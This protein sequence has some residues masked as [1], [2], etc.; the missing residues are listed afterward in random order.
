MNTIKQLLIDLTQVPG[1]SGEEN[2]AAELALSH[3]KKYDPQA[4]IKSGSVFAT[5]GTPE[6]GK[7]H[8]LLDAHIDQIGMIVSYITEEGFLKVGFCGGIDRRILLAQ[9]VTVYGKGGKNILRGAICS[10]PPH[11]AKGGQKVPETEE[12][13]IDVGMSSKEEVLKVL[14]PGD[15]IT[16]FTS[17][18]ALL[19]HRLTAPA[20]D[21][22]AG[23]AAILHALHLLEG[24][25]LPCTVSVLFSAQEEVGCRGAKTGAFILQPD[26]AIA[27]DVTHALTQSDKP[28]NCGEMGKGP[29]VGIAP[30]LDRD[31]FQQLVQVAKDTEIPYQIEVMGR[32]TGTNA[33]NIS[34][35]RTGVKCSTLSIPLKY[36]HTPV[37]VLDMKDVENTGRLLA[38]YIKH[39]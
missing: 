20:L 12:I 39:V 22:R 30:V 32:S 37:E 38:E 15:K 7:P 16:F 24:E 14:E 5:L 31:V 33:D 2:S 25:D 23:V 11:L 21:D 36:M 9:Q 13:S 4:Y 28:E 10:L 19:N 35:S 1:V 18:Q 27:V 29:M 3:L 26:I 34:I 6:N 17:P 8:I